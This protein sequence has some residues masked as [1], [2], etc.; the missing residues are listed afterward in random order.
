MV[1][2]RFVNPSL[3]QLCRNGYNK[4]QIVIYTI[5]KLNELNKSFQIKTYLLITKGDITKYHRLFTQHRI[6]NKQI[7]QSINKSHERSRSVKGLL[8]AHLP[9][10]LALFVAFKHRCIVSLQ[11]TVISGRT[12]TS[13]GW[14]LKT[15]IS[16]LNKGQL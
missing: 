9:K 6:Y 11:P 7:T 4:V 10:L 2:S 5:R 3:L 1:I 16:M 12:A 14:S 8:E 13:I 15:V